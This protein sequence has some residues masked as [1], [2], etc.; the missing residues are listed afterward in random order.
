MS[1][2]TSY[3]ERIHG[4]G[5]WRRGF[6]CCTALGGKIFHSNDL[7]AAGIK[8]TRDFSPNILF[9]NPANDS[10]IPHRPRVLETSQIRK[11][12]HL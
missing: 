6:A 2:G 10:E 1:D 7:R 5:S 11:K 3:C 12:T 4:G 8:A 9:D